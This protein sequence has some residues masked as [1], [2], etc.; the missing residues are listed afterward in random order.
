MPSSSY[1]GRFAPSPTGPLHFG[2]LV[3]AL[4]SFLDAR[5]NGGTW[6]VRIEDIDPPRENPKHIATILD[7]LECHGLTWDKKIMYQSERLTNYQ[8]ELDNLKTRQ[9][10]FACKCSRRRLRQ[11]SGVYDG[12]CRTRHISFSNS[13]TRLK[14]PQK[15][16]NDRVKILDRIFGEYS[17]RLSND[18]GD[19]VIKRRDGFFSYQFASV[20][21]DQFQ[22]VTTI[23]RGADLLEST[24]RQ[25]YLQNCLGYQ[26]IEY[27]HIPLVKNKHGQKLSKQNQAVPVHID[28]ASSNLWAALD[29]LNQQPP[30]SIFGAPVTEILSWAMGNWHLQYVQA[31]AKHMGA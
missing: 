12:H 5:V 19:F 20:I 31:K 3:C 4:A 23:V 6:L 21:D 7:Q 2:S 9:L 24:P 11:T 22:G 15:P 13:A 17:Q 18:I 29:W 27:A 8:L 1:V 25:V 30:Q 10:I 26:H 14:V 28:A 16:V